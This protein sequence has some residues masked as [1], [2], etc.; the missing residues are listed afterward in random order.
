MDRM[1]HD[2]V[3]GNLEGLAPGPGVLPGGGRVRG[4]SQVTGRIEG[5]RIR[6]RKPGVGPPELGEFTITITARDLARFDRAF[7][8]AATR[9]G[10][11][12]RSPAAVCSLISD[13]RAALYRDFP[14]PQRGAS[15]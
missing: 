5:W 10:E 14:D 11:V 4:A 7:S 6:R 2:A 15:P 13:F 3:W 12:E 1:D 8:A 9:A